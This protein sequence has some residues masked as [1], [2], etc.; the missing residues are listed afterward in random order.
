MVEIDGIDEND[1]TNNESVDTEGIADS[2]GTDNGFHDTEGT[3]DSEGATFNTR[4]DLLALMSL[5]F[6]G[7][8]EM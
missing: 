2:E 7:M 3:D 4:L 1:G 8:E 6:I 5:H